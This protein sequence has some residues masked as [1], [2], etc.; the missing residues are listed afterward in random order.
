[1]LEMSQIN[2]IRRLREK[3]GC[4]ISEIAER[5]DINWRTAKKYADGDIELQK[6]GKQ[7]R[8]KPVMGPYISIL[9]AWIE[10]DFRS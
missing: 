10:E 1:M 8:S 7:T 2:Y 5:V 3:E 4:S 9:E 6:E